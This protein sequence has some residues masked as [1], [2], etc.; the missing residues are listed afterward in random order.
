[1]RIYVASGFVN[2]RNVRLLQQYLEKCGATITADWTEGAE[3]HFDGVEETNESLSDVCEQDMR[4][5][6]SCTAMVLWLPGARG[7]H[8]ELG[9]ALA[10][11][12]PVI[13][14]ANA[15]TLEGG[16]GY[17]CPFYHHRLVK[18]VPPGSFD[19]VKDALIAA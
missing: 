6:A 1:M 8:V 4:G 12:K 17:S 11:E 13:L 18:V 14:I 5:V 10:L 9:V 16:A 2:W 7:A 15:K 3:A 19:D